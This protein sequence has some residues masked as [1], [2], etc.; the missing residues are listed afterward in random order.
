M[1]QNPKQMR[2]N[3]N[4]NTLNNFLRSIN[5]N[6]DLDSGRSLMEM[7]ESYIDLKKNI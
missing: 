5:Q 1:D 2:I 4:F 7:T 3:F 6:Q